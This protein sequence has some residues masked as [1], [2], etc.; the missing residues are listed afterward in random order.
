VPS[1]T[2]ST[3]REVTRSIC[4]FAGSS[5][6]NNPRFARAASD[7]A[8]ELVA[9]GYGLVYGGARVGLMGVV[10]DGVLQGG[11]TVTGVIPDFLGDKEIAHQGLTELKVV[12][13]MHERKD[14]MAKLADGFI[15]LPGGFGTIE[16]FFEVLTWAQLGLHAKPCGLLDVGGYF[17]HL[18]RFLDHAV[19]NQLLKPANRS[20]VLVDEDPRA[21][22][23]RFDTFAPP[24]M[25]K[26]IRAD[27]T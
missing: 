12:S 4:V 26:W 20:M 14:T 3:P 16:E 24:A 18:L 15:A 19:V 5:P 11:G 13:S 9:R 25:T 2:T 22:L 10:A 7:L 1:S 21:L 6:G 8:R 23:E 17:D 27:V